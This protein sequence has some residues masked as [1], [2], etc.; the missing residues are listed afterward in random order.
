MSH[1]KKEKWNKLPFIILLFIV[2]VIS[3]HFNRNGNPLI[4][5]GAFPTAD[6]LELFIDLTTL[7]S[8]GIIYTDDESIQRAFPQD[9]WYEMNDLLA[10]A[11]YD[12][13]WNDSGI[14]LAMIA[15]DYALV[16][17]YTDR[18]REDNEWLLIWK[19]GERI[20]F[21]N[22]WYCIEPEARKRICD[23]IESWR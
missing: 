4:I 9:E 3:C 19:D 12:T 15:Q 1:Y 2:G 18:P 22:K 10:T 7:D 13:I 14:M 20:K 21:R 6:S 5:E 8:V 16:L 17:Y 23:K 11:R